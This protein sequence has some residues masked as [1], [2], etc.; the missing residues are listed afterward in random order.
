MNE[1]IGGRAGHTGRSCI[2]VPFKFHLQIHYDVLYMAECTAALETTSE[3]LVLVSQPCLDGPKTM[4]TTLDTG[5]KAEHNAEQLVAMVESLHPHLPGLCLRCR[6][7]VLDGEERRGVFGGAEGG[8]RLLEVVRH[9][10]GAHAACPVPGL[11]L[12]PFQRLQQ[13]GLYDFKVIM[14]SPKGCG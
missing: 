5:N 8:G 9:A 2:S 13:H 3:S 14:P 7:L 12:E 1:K 6:A 11:A 4:S 10:N